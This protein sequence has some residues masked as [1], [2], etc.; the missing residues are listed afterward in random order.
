MAQKKT[1]AKLRPAE[2]VVISSFRV[3]ADVIE[4]LDA[5]VA[6]QNEKRRGPRLTR[7]DV[8]RGLIDWA[9]D[10]RPDWEKK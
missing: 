7:N 2:D 10:T 9:A 3:P 4:R 8:I 6:A 1:T 5:W